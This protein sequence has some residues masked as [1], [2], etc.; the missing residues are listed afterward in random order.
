MI[1]TA[2][3]G[4]LKGR[5]SV[6]QLLST[7]HHIGQLLDNKIQTDVLFLDFAKAFDSVDH[8]ILLKKLKN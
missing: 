8:G 5:S 3:H 1:S 7:L 6:T 2:Q 4:F